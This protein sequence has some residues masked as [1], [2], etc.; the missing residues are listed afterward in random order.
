MASDTVYGLFRAR[1]CGLF[2]H[3]VQVILDGIFMASQTKGHNVR[4]GQQFRLW[5]AM[6]QVARSAV[7]ERN[8]MLKR[9]GEL[10]RVVATQ[11]GLDPFAGQQLLAEAD[12]RSVA[13]GATIFGGQGLVHDRL[14]QVLRKVIVTAEAEILYRRFERDITRCS[15][16]LRAGT[17]SE[18]FVLVRKQERHAAFASNMRDMAVLAIGR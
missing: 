14:R 18:R 13:C 11:A 6:G 5:S 15:V 17:G 8:R 3:W 7:F 16:T 12:V 9:P 10:F 1:V 2:A 4:L